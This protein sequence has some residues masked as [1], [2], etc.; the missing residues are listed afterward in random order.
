MTDLD[1]RPG[2]P[3][4]ARRG[5]PAPTYD[6]AAAVSVATRAEPSL[7]RAVR[8]HAFPRLGVE[9]ETDLWFSGLVRTRAP[10]GLVFTPR[11]RP[12]LLR[13]LGT[14]LASA[15]SVD[16]L[17]DVWEIVDSVHAHISPT[18]RLEERLN[19]LT[20]SGRT[21]EIDAALRPALKSVVTE[22]RTAVAEWFAS[23]WER[24]PQAVLDTP[25][26]WKLAQLAR[27]YFADSHAALSAF[28]TPPP[29]GETA[30]IAALLDDVHLGVRRTHDQIEIGAVTSTVGARSVTVPD[31]HPRLLTVLDEDGRLLHDLTVAAGDLT[32]QTVPPGPLRLRNARGTEFELPEAAFQPP[33]LSSVFIGIGTEDYPLQSIA[34]W[35]NSDRLGSRRFSL[36]FPEL[37][38]SPSDA[39]IMGKLA[40]AHSALEVQGGGFAGVVVLS[41][42]GLPVRQILESVNRLPFEHCLIIVDGETLRGERN[43]ESLLSG[44]F[45]VSGPVE[46]VVDALLQDIS[47]GNPPVG[48]FL[49]PQRELANAHG[50][51]RDTIQRALRKL[52]DLGVVESRL[53]SGC[54]VLAARPHPVPDV[55]VLAQRGGRRAGDLLNAVAETLELLP[56]PEEPFFDRRILL[57]QVS[58]KLSHSAR[59]VL[60]RRDDGP[61]FCLP[62]PRYKPGNEG[63]RLSSSAVQPNIDFYRELVN[64]RDPYTYLPHLARSLAVTAFRQAAVGGVEGALSNLREAI[65]H[66]RSVHASGFPPAAAFEAELARSLTEYAKLLANP[67]EAMISAGEAVARLRELVQ[68]HPDTFAPDLAAAL[69]TLA[70]ALGRTGRHAE[71]HDAAAEAVLLQ[72][73]LDRP[74]REAGLAASLET[75]ATQLASSGQYEDGLVAAS[76]AVDIR[77]VLVQRAPEAHLPD[78]ASALDGLAV[79]LSALGRHEQAV[80]T[81]TEVVSIRR[82]LFAEQV[83]FDVSAATASLTNLAV[84][85]AGLERFEDGKQAVSRL[86]FLCGVLRQHGSMPHA[87]DLAAALDALAARLGALGQAPLAGMVAEDAVSQYRALVQ[88][89]SGFR[90]GLASALHT[91]AVQLQTIGQRKQALAAV[92]EAVSLREELPR[93]TALARRQLLESRALRARLQRR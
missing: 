29:P 59:V 92:S 79:H 48:G 21:D 77:R 62:N 55:L 85:L 51:S 75:L 47:A 16:P 18:L 91:K 69:D 70:V 65:E 76:E 71:A 31:T 63:I 68:G 88:G 57:R 42:R 13:R 7:I 40:D 86:M 50:V 73:D 61:H 34:D 22:N 26:A 46:Q 90:V 20:A 53:G 56:D 93:G 83:A 67:E 24:L 72:R 39:E 87:P 5:L 84:E 43:P 82:D 74:D 78:L 14:M 2:R 28:R 23:A 81:L 9:A 45:E 38:N 30:E 89:N 44:S 54:R 52:A 33:D 17:H 15:P 19:W 1:L 49:P 36:A 80:E 3:A 10:S 35:W 25:T 37:M 8:L 60:T 41:G 6:L 4:P 12:G 11:E 66:Y 32:T 64:S 27:P 58:L